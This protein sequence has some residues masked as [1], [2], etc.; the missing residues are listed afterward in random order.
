MN[1]VDS[2]KILCGTCLEKVRKLRRLELDSLYLSHQN[3][4]GSMALIESKIKIKV[5]FS[6]KPWRH[7]SEVKGKR[8]IF[9]NMAMSGVIPVNFT[10]QSFYCLKSPPCTHWI[11]GWMGLHVGMDTTGLKREIPAPVGN[12]NSDFQ[13]PISHYTG[14]WSVCVLIHR[15]LRG[16]DFS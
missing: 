8:H 5:T 10:L 6:T 13:S 9:R 4:S 14:W 1:V 11:W 7:I 12:R 2:L 3:Y 16:S 15:M